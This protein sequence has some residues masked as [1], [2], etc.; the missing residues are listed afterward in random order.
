MTA[1]W[2][3]GLVLGRIRIPAPPFIEPVRVWSA[4][5]SAWLDFP[6]PLLTPPSRFGAN[7]DW[8]PAVLE[9]VLLA[10]AQSHQQP[11]M[12]SLYPYRALRSIYDATLEDPA[13]GINEISAKAAMTDWLRTG[14]T[15]TGW[16]SAV[17]ESG[18]ASTIEERSAKTIEWLD[19]LNAFA[20]HH[21]MAPGEGGAA[22]G[23]TF[24]L[25]TSRS[26]CQD[27][28]FSRPRTRRLLGH[29][30][31]VVDGQGMRRGSAP[32]GSNRHSRN[33]F[34]RLRRQRHRDSRLRTVL[35]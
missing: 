16:P 3:L 1:G 33:A 5:D 6:N 9:S 27:P 24:S 26:S 23:G 32:A 15:Q 21:Y 29:G 4:S 14:D 22:G 19:R 7:N 28:D 25:I 18:H 20:G 10:M 17:P 34:G 35:T 31:V 2:F 8:L 13:R 12:S 11:V 30:R